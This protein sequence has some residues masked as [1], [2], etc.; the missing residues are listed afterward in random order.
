MAVIRGVS[1]ELDPNKYTQDPRTVLE[2]F[3]D[4]LDNPD[5]FLIYE[6]FCIALFFGLPLFGELWFV[7]GIAL[8]WYFS[9]KKFQ[10]PFRIPMTSGEVDYSEPANPKTGKYK[11]GEGISFFGNESGSNKELWFTDSDMRTHILI[12]GTTG[13]GKTESLLSLA[14]NSFVQGS[15]LI[16]V[17]GKGENA[18][19]IKVFAMARAMGREDDLLF[20]NYMTGS[21]DVFGPQEQK[22]SNTVNPFSTGNSGA[23]IQLLVSLM[24]TGEKG[25]DMWSDRAASLAGAV[26][27]TLVY[28]RDQKEILLDVEVIRQ[29]LTLDVLLALYKK[30]TDFPPHIRDALRGYFVSIPGYQDGK[31]KQEATVLEQHGFLQMQ[32]S[33]ILGSLSDEYGFIY[34]SRLGEVDFQDVVLRR[35]ILVVLLP[36]LEKSP[37]EL[38]NL[39]KIVIACVRMMMASALGN[40]VEG[41]NKEV[42]GRKPTTAKMPFMTIFDEYGYYAV[43]GAA[44]MA[45]QG[46]SIG[47]SLIY[48]GQDLPA[49][50]KASKEEAAS[51]VANCIIKICMKLE[52]PGATFE[53]FDKAAGEALTTSTGN[54]EFK[55]GLVTNY[56]PSNNSNL[57]K[58]RRLDVRDLK[59]QN[60]GQAHILFQAGLVRA[61]MFYAN[62]PQANYSRI[63]YFIRVGITER[64]VLER[65]DVSRKALIRAITKRSKMEDLVEIINSNIETPKV[66]RLLSIIKSVDRDGVS[67]DEQM[68]SAV[69]LFGDEVYSQFDE[70]VGSFNNILNNTDFNEGSMNI[71]DNGGGSGLRNDDDGEEEDDDFNGAFLDKENIR[72]A[73]DKSDRM[74]GSDN[75]GSRVEIMEKISNYPEVFPSEKSPDEISDIMNDLS[76]LYDDGELENL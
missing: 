8:C 6:V 65:D 10:L 53:L 64:A 26:L 73:L 30:R 17:D 22:L 34:R 40:T 56:I 4:G 19:Y 57:A 20:I 13:A 21:K 60:S 44:V 74:F 29:Y 41:S 1:K 70:R 52:D 50:E 71:F 69:A 35:R 38:G 62:P 72:E 33:K 23:L 25:G 27:M 47:F 63:N 76:A 61:N 12:F 7:L 18:L 37:D 68:Q 3:R 9:K 36:A 67:V 55:T 15:G 28:M 58:K 16:Y 31:T 59:E 48:A 75:A 43:R 45:A 66:D 42:I 46:R 32:F 49:F 5:N 51:I 14:Y 24:S 39:G 11:K 54:L 2:K